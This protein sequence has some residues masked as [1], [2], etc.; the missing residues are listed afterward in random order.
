MSRLPLAAAAALALL[1]PLAAR[2]QE[3]A[4]RPLTLE[5]I[6][7][8]AVGGPGASGFSWRDATRATWVVS[9]GMGPEAP[10]ALWEFDTT[11]GTKTK[12]LEPVDVKDRAG[13]A[14]KL[15]PRGG[16]WSPKGDV[17]LVGFDH[18]L[19][20]LAPGAEPRRLTNDPEDEEAPTFSP[21]GSRV[22]YV[23][24]SDL[25]TLERSTG[26]ETRLTTTGGEHVFNGKLDW[27]YEEELARRR[28][29]GSY[30]W[31]PDS[32][33]IA[34]LRLDE[35]RVPAFPV[36]D[37]TPVNGKVLPQRYPKSGDENAIPSVHVVDLAGKETAAFA[38]VPDDVY[39]APELA[40][41]ADGS[42]ACFLVLDRPQTTLDVF[43]LPR[44]GGAPKK[45]LTETDPAWI[46]AIEP[47]L[48]LQDGTFL[49]RSERTGFQHLDRHAPD[50]TLLNAVT[51]GDWMIDGPWTV[52]EKAGLVWFTATEK[53]PRER[54]VYRV[55]LDGTGFQRVTRERGHHSLIP[56]PA[57]GLFVSAYSS[58]TTPPKTFV[59]DATGA[60]VGV[61]DDAADRWAGYT[62]GSIEMDS[63]RGSDGT[64][65][66]TRLVK[67]VPFDPAKKYPAIV[68]V[69]GGPHAQEVQDRWT[70][71]SG[72]D[73][74]LASKGFLVW[75]MDN[76]GSWGRGH[77]F[78]TPLLKNMGTQELK[79]Q[80]EGL[81]ELR[82]K[83]FV[84]AARLGIWG[85]S[86]GGYLTL[87]AVTHTNGTFKCA[88]AGAPVTD[89]KLYDSIYTERYM[90]R[91]RD[92]PEGYKASSALEAAKNLSTKLLVM[93]GT[94]D[95][96][97]HMQ[98]S[99]E[100]LDELM[101]ARKDFVFV[102]LP[103]QQHGPRREALLYRNQRLVE[104][105]EK[106]L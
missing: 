65:F 6:S 22:A 52:D 43:L 32:S 7:E 100:F 46:N 96:N 85:W 59:R 30:E 66:Y 24:K 29:R 72:L 51:K 63:F 36:V 23:K 71:T 61:L 40:W 92:N 77:A 49:F 80:L 76:R 75:T 39:V 16:K 89:W 14:R 105:F 27:V 35:N 91:P 62:L 68:F 13:T 12:L 41:T 28:G 25:F 98:N 97:V 73:H 101:K 58:A 42:H 57:R 86:Y 104:W 103:R 4:K 18:D 82:K 1:A 74:Y 60:L 3:G 5:K 45:L 10:A 94:S 8:P 17:L 70:S 93:H 106:N 78:E 79:D 19:W 34:Y 20:L 67:P 69:Y 55:K 11:R 83:P 56:A 38:P 37:F 2:S 64:L 81:A 88:M 50:G 47:P 9:E 15:S 21:D 31:A 48:F 33:A 102:P 84:D 99:I 26:R 87:F 54:H 95:D 53:D 90:R 44:S